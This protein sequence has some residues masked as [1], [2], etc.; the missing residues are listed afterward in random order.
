[1][2]RNDKNIDGSCYELGI[3]LHNVVS[4]GDAENDLAFLRISACSAAVANALPSV[5]EQADVV[6]EQPRG[7]GVIELSERLIADDLAGFDDKLRRDAIS[8]GHRIDSNDGQEQVFVGPRQG[9]IL[10]SGPSGSGKSTA[11]GG[12][13]EQLVAHGYQFC[14][15]DPEGDYEGFT[16]ALSFGTAK[17]APDVKALFRAL[18]FP[19]Q[20]VLVDLLGVGVEDRPGFFGTLLPHLQDL[21]SR[22][23]RPHWLIIDE[24]HHMLPSSWT[25]ASG[26]VPQVLQATI[27]ISVHP[28][29]VAKPVLDAVDVIVAIGKPKAVFQSFAQALQISAPH[30]D[31][32]ELATG[33]AMVWFR[34]TSA[35]PIHVKT[36]Q[37]KK[38]R[39]RHVRNYA[40]GELSPDQSFH[41]RGPESKMNLR[42]QNL[43]TFLQLADGVDDE[44]WMFHLRKNDYS[45]WFQSVIKDDELGRQA[46][47][48]E[49]DESVSPQDSRRKIKD[50]VESR[51]TAPA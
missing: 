9:S 6:L 18:E 5:K 14:L 12:L 51:Y 42:A 48:V 33:E 8:L 44:T 24:A 16:G 46:A 39:L 36:I 43:R 10:V 3:S 34:H 15:I 31:D 50:A 21:R 41:F 35:A 2:C 30:G 11:V 32:R 38:E 20:S 29:H 28:E 25:P 26:T 40:E 23:A 4:V 27:L 1:M 7:E 13:L 47:E 19:E 17:D 37:S 49:Q 45:G 22:T